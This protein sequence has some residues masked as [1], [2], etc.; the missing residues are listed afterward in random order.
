MR[1]TEGILNDAIVALR[2]A[3]GRPYDLQR[4]GT[5][6][7]VR[8]RVAGR[9]ADYF[10]DVT[11]LM[12]PRELWQWL[13]GAEWG[14]GEPEAEPRFDRGLPPKDLVTLARAAAEQAGHAEGRPSAFYTSL[15]TAAVALAAASDYSTALSDLTE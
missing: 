13:A 10:R 5:F 3:T 2:A 15:Q 14:L 8:V 11:S 4:T 12:S 7:R 6:V 9:G 1:I